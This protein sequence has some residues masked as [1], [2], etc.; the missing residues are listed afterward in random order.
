[1]IKCVTPLL[2]L[3]NKISICFQKIIK[4]ST[5]VLYLQYALHVGFVI[6]FSLVTVDAHLGVALDSIRNLMS[7]RVL[8]LANT[9]FNTAAHEYEMTINSDRLIQ[10]CDETQDP[11]AAQLPTLTYNFVP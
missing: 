4:F 5:Q 9:K 3:V 6:R 10:L 8:R 11:Q 2:R 1:M 7:I